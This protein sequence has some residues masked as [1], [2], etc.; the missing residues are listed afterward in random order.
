[1]GASRESA[2]AAFVAAGGGASGNGGGGVFPDMVTIFKFLSLAKSFFL[3]G[4]W[5]K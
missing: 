1:M 3:E 5:E 4:E 2:T